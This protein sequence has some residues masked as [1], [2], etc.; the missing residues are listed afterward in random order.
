MSKRY[1]YWKE[2]KLMYDT[3]TKRLIDPVDLIDVEETSEENENG[4]EDSQL[5]HNEDLDSFH[6]G[7]EIASK[8][9][10][11]WEEEF[12]KKCVKCVEKVGGK[13]E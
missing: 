1:V 4:V 7:A 10:K 8:I 9:I 3:K 11:K 12:A 6:R 13:S 2:S 5:D